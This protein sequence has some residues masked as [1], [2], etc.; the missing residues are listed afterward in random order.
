M[1]ETRADEPRTFDVDD[2][3]LDPCDER[4]V[5]AWAEF[6]QVSPDEIRATCEAVGPNRTAVELKLA[7]PEA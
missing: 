4:Q 6:Y 2:Q 1:P 7:A 5:Q 3:L